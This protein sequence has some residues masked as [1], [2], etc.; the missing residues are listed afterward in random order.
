MDL[1]LY[2]LLVVVL[3]SF[4]GAKAIRKAQRGMRDARTDS[5]SSDMGTVTDANTTDEILTLR[6]V[7]SLLTIAQGDLKRMA[8]TGKIPAFRVGGQLRFRRED[9][10]RLIDERTNKKPTSEKR[11]A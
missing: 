4:L 7:S 3:V 8:V 5:E 6:E 2:A 11:D 10:N 9:I 1:W